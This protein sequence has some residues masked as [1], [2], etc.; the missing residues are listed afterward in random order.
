MGK[1]AKAWEKAKKAQ[2]TLI[3][4]INKNTLI[5][6]QEVVN[7]LEFKADELAKK[8]KRNHEKNLNSE[9][10]KIDSIQH[11]EK[12]P[13]IMQ[14]SALPPPVMPTLVIPPP[15]G[16]KTPPY[17]V[18]TIN[19]F[20][21]LKRLYEDMIT[22]V[23]PDITKFFK[24]FMPLIPWGSTTVFSNCFSHGEHQN[25]KFM[26]GLPGTM[27]GK[28]IIRIFTHDIYEDLLVTNCFD[29]ERTVHILAASILLIHYH[30]SRVARSR[31]HY[32]AR[33]VYNSL[34][35]DKNKHQLISSSSSSSKNDPS[36]NNLFCPTQRVI[37]PPPAKPIPVP[38]APA[39]Q[40]SALAAIQ[41]VGT[42]P[43]KP[44][45]VPPPAPASELVATLPKQ[46]ISLSFSDAITK[47][48]SIKEI[49]EAADKE[50]NALTLQFQ[51]ILAKVQEKALKDKEAFKKEEKER[52]IELAVKRL[53]EEKR[54][55]DELI[56][57]KEEE[58]KALRLEAIAILEKEEK[59]KEKERE[60]EEALRLEAIAFLKEEE[61]ES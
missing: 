10:K 17:K 16:F 48:Q 40:A 44:I 56:R 27:K 58:E 47:M 3:E 37:P 29:D 54:K 35:K 50:I 46:M 15:A 7:F 42:S 55:A 14:P 57:L 43:A 36:H 33:D 61:E 26:R 24:A 13:H 4:T 5:P 49:E 9:I 21:T 6:D 59:E 22:D 25:S 18:T 20:E 8:E 19:T 12:T 28:K 34:K 31:V 32:E 39:A 53:R 23:N 51:E 30:D 41:R 2:V 1:S 52:E 60:E 45:P 38:P 11:V